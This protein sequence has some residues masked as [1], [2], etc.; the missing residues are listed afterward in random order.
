M[1]AI[2]FETTSIGRCVTPCPAGLGDVMAGPIMV[3]SS[4]C[5]TCRNNRGFDL[6]IKVVNCK[7][8]GVQVAT[9]VEKICTHCLRTKPASAF[10]KHN[11]NVDGLRGSCKD[12]TAR[13]NKKT[14][15]FPIRCQTCRKERPL[16]SYN[17]TSLTCKFC[18]D[19]G[20]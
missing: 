7:A 5:Q 4:A 15:R 19:E 18:R 17:N 14:G 3:G 12:C 1:K 20:K 11:T 10:Y 6:N 2:R 8:Q 13:Y 16:N 9:N